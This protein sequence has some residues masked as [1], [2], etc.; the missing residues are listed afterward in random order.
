MNPM[1][2]EQEPQ[3]QQIYY[4]QQQQGIPPQ[5]QMMQEP[6]NQPMYGIP[7]QYQ[8]Q[9][10]NMNPP[11]YQPQYQLR[12]PYETQQVQPPPQAQPI[13]V[14]PIQTQYQPST[15]EQYNN[16]EKTFVEHNDGPST[17]YSWRNVFYAILF[18]ISLIGTG[19]GAY[20][21]FQSDLFDIDADT[22]SDDTAWDS[23]EDVDTLKF[24]KGFFAVK[25]PVI[26]AGIGTGAIFTFFWLAIIMC[27]ASSIIKLCLLLAPVGWVLSGLGIYQWVGVDGIAGIIVSFIMAAIFA[28][29]ACSVWSKIPFATVCLQ[30]AVST[31]RQ[32]KAPL[33]VN[34]F[35]MILSV[36]RSL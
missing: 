2:N 20:L 13:Y 4:M 10:S 25:L 28:I 5:S 21:F 29:Y 31:F 15:I 30:I 36:K 24:P 8:Q 9:P 1:R 22:D 23:S 26:F 6:Q 35:M 27:C 16:G 11:T 32:F 12:N 33:F 7:A 18:Y 14:Q 19:L 3:N 17:D 34:V